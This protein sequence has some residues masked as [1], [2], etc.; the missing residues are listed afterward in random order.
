[1]T[2][3]SQLLAVTQTFNYYALIF[4]FTQIFLKW[5]NLGVE[6]NGVVSIEYIFL[7]LHLRD[8]IAEEGYR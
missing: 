4:F 5:V 7:A 3:S 8:S 6:E 1:M 2:K